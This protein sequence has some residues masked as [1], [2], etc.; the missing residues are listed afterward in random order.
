MLVVVPVPLAGEVAV[1]VGQP[2]EEPV[3]RVEPDG[4]PPLTLPA[5]GSG[6][7]SP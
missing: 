6:P 4:G 1:R 7:C 5:G 3:G 2:F